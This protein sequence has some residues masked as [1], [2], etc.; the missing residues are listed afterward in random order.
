MAI[1]DVARSLVDLCRQG[2]FME[3][4]EK[5]YSQDIVSVEAMGNEQ[6]PRVMEGLDAVRG[7]SEW[8]IDNHEV[9]SNEIHG[10]YY[11]G[12]QFSMFMVTD[13][14]S[15]PMNQRYT[16]KEVCLYDVKDDKIVKEHFY[17]DMSNMG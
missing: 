3:A 11:N 17:Y 12:D 16:M 15:K 5:H 8:W 10:P 13:V 4:I 6:M 14:T 1:K 7:K 9:H 2:K